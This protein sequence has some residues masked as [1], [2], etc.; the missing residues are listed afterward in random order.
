VSLQ[1][2]LRGALNYVRALLRWKSVEGGLNIDPATGLPVGL[3]GKITLRDG[4]AL[5]HK[6]YRH[7]YKGEKRRQAQRL[8]SLVRAELD[9]E[10]A[11]DGEVPRRGITKH[12]KGWGGTG[13]EPV[14]P[15]LAGERNLRLVKWTWFYS[16]DRKR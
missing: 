16:W 14:T 3:T 13:L 4:G 12:F 5:F 9:E 8:E 7:L 6:T 1:G 2:V 15:S 10:G 11:S